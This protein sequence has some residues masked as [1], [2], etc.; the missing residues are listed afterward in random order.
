MSY[1]DEVYLKRMNKDG[2]TIQERVKTR[3][4]KEFDSLFLKRTKYQSIIYQVNDK[5]EEIVCSLQP[6]KWN[7]DNLISNLLVSTKSQLFKTGDLLFIFWKNKE[8]EQNKIWLVVYVDQNLTR[9]YQS[10][11][12]ICLDETLCY[13]N[14]Y[15][16]T[17]TNIPIKLVNA[18]SSFVQDNF[19]SS[20]V[21]YREANTSRRIITKDYSFLKKDVYFNYKNQ[22]WTI[23]GKD[24][25]SIN[26]VAYLSIS[27]QL[28]REPEPKTSEDLLV[29]EDTNFFLNNR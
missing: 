13:K 4:E 6:N 25:M 1:F 22:S 7:Q 17:I 20:G 26:G 24:N 15:G 23:V 21:Q 27:E 11:Q 3:K 8:F 2:K 10:Y 29:G 16:D 19:S 14:E 28:A 9:G 12:I 5:K 18:S